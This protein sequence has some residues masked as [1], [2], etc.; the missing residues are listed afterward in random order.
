M[1]FI[2]NQYHL[3]KKQN[4]MYFDNTILKSFSQ[5]STPQKET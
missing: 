5:K 1:F 3:N 2:E 4:N